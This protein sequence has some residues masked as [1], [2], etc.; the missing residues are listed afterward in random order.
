MCGYVYDPELG[1]ADNGVPA[2]TPFED[3]PVDWVCPKCGAPK[4]KF[5]PER[6]DASLTL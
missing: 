4:R 2:G 6:P 1:V 5:L 3:L